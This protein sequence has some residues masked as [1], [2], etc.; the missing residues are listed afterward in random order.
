MIVHL[1]KDGWKWVALTVPGWNKEIFDSYAE[2]EMALKARKLVHFK[3]A[4]GNQIWK[5]IQ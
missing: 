1:W 5:P 4:G 2:A 3:N